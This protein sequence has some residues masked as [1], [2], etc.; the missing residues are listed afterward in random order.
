MLRSSL[1]TGGPKPPK[2]VTFQLP[3][4][5]D[6]FR[7]LPSRWTRV[8]EFEGGEGDLYVREIDYPPG[9]QSF[10][11]ILGPIDKSFD[12]VFRRSTTTLK[13]YYSHGRGLVME[14]DWDGE[15]VV[16]FSDQDA[17]PLAWF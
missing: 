16:G 17:M 6:Q 1:A 11:I 3:P 2:K 12:I 5:Y 13:Q 4:W 7:C 10:R 14:E 9:R 8:E 15:W